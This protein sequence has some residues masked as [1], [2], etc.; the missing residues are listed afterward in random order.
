MG[1]LR[2]IDYARVPAHF[3]EGRCEKG[4]G[5]MSEDSSGALRGET[6]DAGE[7]C[8][9]SLDEVQTARSPASLATVSTLALATAACG[10]GG[11]NTTDYSTNKHWRSS[12]NW[13]VAYAYLPHT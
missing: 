4:G 3:S 12:P 13:R 2:A 11:G 10:G 6:I 8:E 5:G 9:T 7:A 1:Y